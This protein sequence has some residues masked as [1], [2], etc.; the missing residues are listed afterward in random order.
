MFAAYFSAKE[1]KG[2]LE[3]L[4]FSIE[5]QTFYEKDNR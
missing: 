5:S 3:P 2:I 1:L 4:D